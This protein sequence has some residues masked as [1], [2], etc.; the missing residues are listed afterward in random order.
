MDLVR[1][2][3]RVQQ[4]VPSVDSFERLYSAEYASLVVMA[5]KL[6]GSRTIAEELVQEGFLR[7]YQ[8]WDRI[9]GYDRPGAWVRRVVLNLATSRS[10]RL[11]RRVV[12]LRRV[13][14]QRGSEA[15]DLST[16]TLEFWALVRGLSTRQAQVVVLYYEA[17]RSI[18]EV[19]AILGCGEGTVRAHLHRA[20]QALASRLRDLNG[21]D[22]Q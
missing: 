3:R 8:R 17:D 13:G 10:R 11:A 14:A 5:F 15:L 1:T 9:G 21:E 12:A 6:T 4:T 2:E 22:E 20:R 7:A 19:A 16:D 18:E